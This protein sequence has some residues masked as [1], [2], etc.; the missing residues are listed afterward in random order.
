MNHVVQEKEPV[1]YFKGLLSG[2]NRSNVRQI[3]REKTRDNKRV[4]INITTRPNNDWEP[5]HEWSKYK[6]LLNLPGFGDWSNRFKYLFLLGSVIINVNLVH[7]ILLDCDPIKKKYKKSYYKTFTDFVLVP[8]VDYINIDY[9]YFGKI[10]EYKNK[11][12]FMKYLD[13]E[14]RNLLI[15][16]NYY[17]ANIINNPISYNKMVERGHDK[18]CKLTCSRLNQYLCK[19]IILSNKITGPQPMIIKKNWS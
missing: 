4:K 17:Y 3:L 14:Q 16:L 8:N 2:F 7:E 18:I 11:G 12:L 6:I 10:H 5:I 15:K 13:M 1:M 9:R 19:A